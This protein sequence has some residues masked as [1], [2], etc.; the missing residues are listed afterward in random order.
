MARR[1]SVAAPAATSTAP[2]KNYLAVLR[3]K[4][5]TGD[6]NGQAVVDG[7]AETLTTR[8]AQFSTVQIMRPPKP[9]AVANASP[10]QAARELGANVV[11]TGSMM[12]NGDRL[13]V[14]YAVADMRTNSSKSDLIDGSVNDLLAVQYRVAYSVA[15][16][17]NIGAVTA[18]ALD[19]QV[20]QQ[21]FLEALGYLRRYDDSES[22]DKAISIL[23]SLGTSATVQA[24][25]GRAYLYK[26]QLT[27]EPKWAEPAAGACERALKADFAFVKAWKADKW[28]NLVYRKTA[29]NF[30]PVM[31]TAGRITIA[32][33]EHLVEIGS[34][35]PDAVHTPAIYV[36][37]MFQA[38]HYEKRIEKRTVR[39]A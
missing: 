31:A 36:Q 16:S 22:V 6:A 4:D 7:F 3:F 21:R 26:F 23:S 37:R 10:Q 29:R 5:L 11:V 33:I 30:N 25:L 9:D 15:A 19:P 39:E 2:Q 34:I 17:L 1:P 12:R 20:S 28:G 27:H 18:Y 32:E 38:S 14:T 35:D 8:L 24:S 13:R